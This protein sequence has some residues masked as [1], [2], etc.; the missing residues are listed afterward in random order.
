M[1]IFGLMTLFPLQVFA[2]SAYDI[3]FNQA[4]VLHPVTLAM[5]VAG[6]TI[7]YGYPDEV[8]EKL[9]R[10]RIFWGIVWSTF[11]ALVVT[12]LS[13]DFMGWDWAEHRQGPLA[14]LLAATLRVM[15][16]MIKSAIP[17][18]LRN[19][20]G[21]GASVTKADAANKESEPNG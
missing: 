19:W 6:A 21:R 4:F 16:P 5:A 18:F 2:T 1:A 10:K 17:D 3:V 7:S 15:W 11:I 12:S 8:D 13:I 9:S 20:G 14:G